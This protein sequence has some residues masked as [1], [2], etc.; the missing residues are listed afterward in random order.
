MDGT[1]FFPA[2]HQ[3]RA[4]KGTQSTSAYQW[5][6]HILFIPDK[7]ITAFM[8]GYSAPVPLC[9]LTV[10]AY[11]LEFYVSR[12]IRWNTSQPVGPSD[13]AVCQSP[14]HGGTAVSD[15]PTSVE[16]HAYCEGDTRRWCCS[17]VHLR[18]RCFHANCTSAE[19]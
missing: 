4:V 5:L 13:G 15:C 9:L 19:T 6:D 18:A 17:H 8:A 2:T 14:G 16:C 7:G 12:I 11:L 1:S 3:C 10:L